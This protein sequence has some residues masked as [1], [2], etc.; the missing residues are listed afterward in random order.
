MIIILGESGSGKTT[1][2]KYICEHTNHKKV[3]SHTTR[4]MRNG[5]VDGKDYYFINENTFHEMLNNKKFAEASCYRDWFYAV[6][7]DELF[8]NSC[9]VATPRGARL[10]KK[11]AKEK[12]LN[13]TTIYLKVDKVSRLIQLLKRDGEKGLDESYRRVTS[14]SGMFDGIEDEVDIVINNSEYRFDVETLFD[15]LR[16][17]LENK[18]LKL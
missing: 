2:Q 9:F 12:E 16:H 11:I 17:E 1:L 10:I 8:D 3:I 14:D 18:D 4:P 7:Y 5:E 15:K 6:S 13:I